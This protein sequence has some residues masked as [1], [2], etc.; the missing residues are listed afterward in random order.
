MHTK[1]STEWED[2]GTYW[3]GKGP[4]GEELK[5]FKKIIAHTLGINQCNRSL[6]D[7]QKIA[8]ISRT[9]LQQQKG[10]T[11]KLAQALPIDTVIFT[12]K[13]VF[14]LIDD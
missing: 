2:H 1:A 11:V 9:A 7:H 6:V 10:I 8:T 13:G 3:T 14:R 12:E 4:D 5:V